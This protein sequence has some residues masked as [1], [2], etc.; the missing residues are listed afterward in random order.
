MFIFCRMIRLRYVLFSLFAFYLAITAA[1]PDAATAKSRDSGKKVEDN[2]IERSKGRQPTAP[3][4]PSVPT[5]PTAPTAPS[6]PNVVPTA[7]KA[8]RVFSVTHAAVATQLATAGSSGHQLGDMR[9]LP[10]TPI[11]NAAGD[12]VGRLDAQLL[13]TSV[14]FPAA[15]DEVRMSTLNFVFGAG[16]ANLTGSADQLLVS[17]SG[18]YPSTQSTLPTGT[19]LVRPIIGGSGAYAGASGWAES[20]HLIDGTWRHTFYLLED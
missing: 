8:K 18:F 3:T 10:A 11:Q 20:E 1:G 5:A 13:T 2:K 9:V 6:T 17:G 4:P 14:D 7:P 12:S 16:A 19:S 15:G